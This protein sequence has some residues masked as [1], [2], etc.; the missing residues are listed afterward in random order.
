MFD[1]YSRVHVRNLLT[2]NHDGLTALYVYIPEATRRFAIIEAEYKRRYLNKF[3]PFWKE[4]LINLENA[5][6]K[7]SRDQNY[8]TLSQF[9]QNYQLGRA[10][11]FYT[12]G[13]VKLLEGR[14]VRDLNIVGY[15]HETA[16]VATCRAWD[17]LRPVLVKLAKKHGVTKDDLLYYLPEE[18]LQLLQFGKKL[19]KAVLKQRRRY[20]ILLLKRGKISLYTGKAARSIEAKELSKE[21]IT[22]LRELKG[23]SASSGHVQ[24]RVRIV[25]TAAQMQSMKNGEIL[26][27]IM[28]TPRLL[29]A[30]KKAAAIVTDE[31][32]ITCHAAIV[33]R[34]LKKPCIIGTKIATHVFKDGDF[35][36]VDAERG[37]VR[38]L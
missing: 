5:T 10:I 2:V 19:S 33:A 20:Y 21:K 16:E 35:V 6:K 13:L 36:E 29:L 31:G 7:F 26:V 1:D 17:L 22:A 38:K 4:I 12:E 14:A 32:G 23:M 3:L 30:A 8:E 9:I 25:N 28:T 24:G 34:E 15:W 27:S 11:V 18:F 37:V